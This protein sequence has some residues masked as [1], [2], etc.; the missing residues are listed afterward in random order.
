MRSIIPCLNSV[1]LRERRV[2][3][4]FHCCSIWAAPP[5]K[6]AR[7]DCRAMPA[8]KLLIPW[9]KAYVKKPK[10][11][12]WLPWRYS[13]VIAS[14]WHCKR[15]VDPACHSNPPCSLG[16][17]SRKTSISMGNI[18]GTSNLHLLDF[19]YDANLA[20]PFGHCQ[21]RNGTLYG[22]GNHS[23]HTHRVVRDMGHCDSYTL[24]SKCAICKR[25]ISIR[26]IH[27]IANYRYVDQF[28][29]AVCKPLSEERNRYLCA[30]A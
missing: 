22:R 17:H 20:L 24:P 19:H 8:A 12:C 7:L 25:C 16:T 13:F 10:N 9:R 4:Y 6:P 2:I 11:Y 1:R 14:C 5:L 27:S 3:A 30:A 29:K 26:L 21:N 15:D 18:R 28:Q 23:D